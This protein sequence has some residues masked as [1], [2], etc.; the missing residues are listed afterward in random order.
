MGT[1]TLVKETSE[2]CV[3]VRALAKLRW[4]EDPAAQVAHPVE[5]FLA[6]EQPVAAAGSGKQARGERRGACRL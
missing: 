1:I 3:P 6:A 2:A 4:M 5:G